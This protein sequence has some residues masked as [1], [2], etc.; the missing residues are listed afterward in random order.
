[1]DSL[2]RPQPTQ[3][4]PTQPNGVV[5]TPRLVLRP[6]QRDDL[7]VMACWSP[8]QDPLDGVWNWPQVLRKQGSVDLFWASRNLDPKRLEWTIVR[9]DGTVVGYLGIRN[10]DWDTGEAWLGIGFGQPYVGQGYGTEALEAF[11]RYFFATLQFIH[12]RLE[13]ALHNTSARRLYQ[14][15]GFRDI[16][17]FWYLAE[18]PTDWTFLRD[19]RYDDVRHLFRQGQ[20]GMY[21]QCVEMELATR[22]E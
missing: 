13:V 3:Q 4:V 20:D 19:P 1:M 8:F 21:I 14:R 10:I 18:L 11:L 7:D 9:H 16:R 15:L 5:I 17:T 12:L 22:G 2:M 6:W